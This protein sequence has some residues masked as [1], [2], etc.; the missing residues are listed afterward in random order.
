[1]TGRNV[2]ECTGG[3][4]DI[5][6]ERLVDHYDTLC[7]PRLNASQGLELAFLI[8]EELKNRRRSI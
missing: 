8:S 5:T 7:D 3:A 2:T 6:E 1:M 4:Q